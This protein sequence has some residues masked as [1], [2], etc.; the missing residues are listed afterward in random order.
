MKKKILYFFCIIIGMLVLSYAYVPQVLDGKIVNQS[1]ISG[2]QGMSREM[3]D[4][5]SAHPDDPTAWTESMFG[6][7]PTAT[8]H[9]ATDGDWTQ[10]IYDFLLT[11][12]RP[13]TYLF[14]SL[15]GAWLLMLAFGVHPLIAVGGAVAVTFCSYNL[16]IIQVG[17]N[18]KMQAIAF[19]PWVL[20]ALVYTYNAALKKKKWLPSC[21]FGAAM[22]ALFVSF[23]VKANHP[24]ITYYLA[25]MILLYAL[26]LLVWLL[27]RK[28][29]RGLLGR[30]FAASGLLLVL[31]CTGIATNAI[32][33]LPTFEYTP[34]SMRGGSTAEADG[35]KETKG[36]ELD[37]ATAWSYG[38][39]ELPNLLI[40]N[41]N[42]G[43]SAGSVDP[44]KSETIALL[45]SAGQPGARSMADSLPMYWGPQPFTAGPMYMGAVTIFLFVLALFMYKGKEKWWI[46]VCSVLAVFLA[47]GSHFMWFTRLFYD[48]VPL[49]NKFRTVS[50][51][52]VVLQFTLPLLAFLALDRILK[53]G[54]FAAGFRKKGFWALAVSGGFCLLFLLVPSLAGSFTGSVDSGQPDILVEALQADRKRLL[55]SDALRS[56]LLVAAAY[57]LILWGVSAPKKGMADG[58]SG[59]VRRRTAVLLVCVLVLGDL[60]LA[61]K[62]YLNAGDFV[63]PRNF[64]SQFDKRP[65]D[66]AIL[67]DP[68]L[69]YRVLDLTVNV[70]NDSHPSY[71]HKNIGGYSPAKLQRYQE[72]IESTLTSEINELYSS[73]SSAGTVQEAEENMPYLEGLAKMNCRYIIIADDLALRYKYA[74]GNAW[75]AQACLEAGDAA[76]E[77]A[78]EP[79]RIELVSYAPNELRYEYSSAEGGK[80][81]FSE[82][83][84][85][86]GWTLMVE[87]TG[88]LLPIG[89]EGDILRSA[90]VPA[91]EHTLVMRFDPPSYRTGETVSRASSI[92][93]VL[94]VLLSA[95]FVAVPALSRKRK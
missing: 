72:F 87:D 62:R 40:P 43:S 81:V 50:M 91:G 56:L 65:V 52:L 25:I 59:F 37:Y 33:L 19:L 58:K 24:Q 55:V 4:W 32:K 47:L 80:V 73:I 49:Y 2:W 82:V 79:D 38:W 67:S 16:Q 17:H 90:L 63:T 86:V 8:I 75:F 15:V 26:M 74:A 76:E 83:Y 1:D 51:A 23:Q 46:V 30:F 27:R 44:D 77:A 57:F 20:A 12:R 94:V 34:Y 48:C 66:E 85:P 70:F 35:S 71:W 42:G 18:T 14:I 10:K 9:A 53:D 28:E 69:S 54:D 6:G 45:E 3:M 22:F 21:A 31:G 64:Q 88:E 60:G 92:A 78:A 93:I 11:G 7:M 95:G 36:L 84:Y 89:L 29:R 5:N 13:A 39:E 61:G 68:D 41:F